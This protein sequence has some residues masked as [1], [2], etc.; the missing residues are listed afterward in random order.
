MERDNSGLKDQKEAAAA[1]IW[2]VFLERWS[3]SCSWWPFC[4][5]LGRQVSDDPTLR[6]PVPPH[7]NRPAQML[8]SCTAWA[9]SI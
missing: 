3:C 1:Q 2:A 8:H 9:W 5:L 4:P 6:G 7:M